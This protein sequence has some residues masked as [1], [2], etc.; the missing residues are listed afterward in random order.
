MDGALA[1]EMQDTQLQALQ[2]TVRDRMHLLAMFDDIAGPPGRENDNNAEATS[3]ITATKV[4]LFW[5]ALVRYIG[6]WSDHGEYT[7]RLTSF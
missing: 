5:P 6:R 3:P 2:T 4:R 1:G 7:S